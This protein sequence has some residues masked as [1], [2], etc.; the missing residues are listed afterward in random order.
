[1]QAAHTFDVKPRWPLADIS[2]E[3]AALSNPDYLIS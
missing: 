1:L 3:A 2:R